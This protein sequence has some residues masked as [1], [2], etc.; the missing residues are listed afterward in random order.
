MEPPFPTCP[1]CG[2]RYTNAGSHRPKGDQ[3]D[4][5]AYFHSAGP[6]DAVWARLAG[7]PADRFVRLGSLGD[8]DERQIARLIEE[9]DF[10]FDLTMPR[11]REP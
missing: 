3:S 4:V 7:D 8:Y 5:I 10:V 2:A 1:S 11:S 9:S 6:C